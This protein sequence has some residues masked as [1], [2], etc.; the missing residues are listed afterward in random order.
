MKKIGHTKRAS[1]VEL[2]SVNMMVREADKYD[3]GECTLLGGVK[4]KFAGFD[5]G[6]S[7]DMFV[8]SEPDDRII[9]IPVFFKIEGY[10]SEMGT[11]LFDIFNIEYYGDEIQI[12]RW[13]EDDLQS[14]FKKPKLLFN[15]RKDANKLIMALKKINIDDEFDFDSLMSDEEL[16]EFKTGYNNLLSKLTANMLW[17]QT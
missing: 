5:F 7:H 2:H 4:A 6:C 16:V 13:N 9:T 8:D 11:D 14:I 10:K 17:S 3:V 15:N 12:L 1:D